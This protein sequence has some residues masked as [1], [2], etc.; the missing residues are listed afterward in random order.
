MTEV[1]VCV[2]GVL[3]VNAG[4][5]SRGSPLG[6][7]LDTDEAAAAAVYTTLDAVLAARL[8]NDEKA[9]TGMHTQ[10]HTHTYDLPSGLRAAIVF[11][12]KRNAQTRCVHL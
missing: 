5:S 6:K 9:L 10:I 3:C 1:K 7:L 11:A 4:S 12:D 8:E 2:C